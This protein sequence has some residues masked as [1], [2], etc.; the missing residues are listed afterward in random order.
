MHSSSCGAYYHIESDYL[1][2]TMQHNC[3]H[4]YNPREL[5]FCLMQLG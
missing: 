1:Y 3:K 5:T 4:P 2:T